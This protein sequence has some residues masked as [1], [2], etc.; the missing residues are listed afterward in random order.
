MKQFLC[1]LLSCLA[2]STAFAQQKTQSRYLPDLLKPEEG[3]YRCH[4]IPHSTKAD[5]DAMLIGGLRWTGGIVIGYQVGPYHPG[6][7]TFRLDG[8]YERLLFVMGPTRGSEGEY[9]VNGNSTLKALVG[10]YADGR[11]VLD[12][13][14]SVADVPRRYS[15]DVK[16]VQEIR[17]ALEEGETSIGFA[18]MTLWK[19]GENPQESGHLLPDKLQ[20][21]T[22]VKDLQ[23]F[24]MNNRVNAEDAFKMGGTEY[25]D[26]LDMDASVV[27][28]GTGPGWAR[29]FLQGGYA[30]LSFVAGPV[31]RAGKA[32]GTGWLT[33]KADGKILYER[34]I[35]SSDLPEPVVLDIGHCQ[36]LVFE[37]ENEDR[38]IHIGVGSIKVYPDGVEPEVPVSKAKSLPDAIKLIS[39]I[40]PYASGSS[41]ENPLFDGS[42]VHRVFRMG[43]EQ[44]NEGIVL[45]STANMLYGNSG[46]FVAFDLDGA[47]DEVHFTTGWTGNSGVMKD[48]TLRV[49]TDDRLIGTIALQATATN[50]RYTLPLNRCRK[51]KFELQGMDSFL[52]PDFGLGDI[53]V[54]RN[55]A[56]DNLFSHPAPPPAPLVNLLDISKPY[57]HYIYPLRDEME[58]ALH[59]GST[60]R[61]WFDLD[62]QRIHNG[63]LLQTSVHLTLDMDGLAGALIAL[64]FIGFTPLALAAAGVAHE[65]SVAAF[66]TYGDYDVL[67]FKVACLDGSN[68]GT[69][70]PVRETLHIGTDGDLAAT[71][72][73]METMAP[74]TFEIPLNRCKQLMFWLVCTD[75]SS[76]KYLI[77][78]AQLLRK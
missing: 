61:R 70:R 31:D 23:P 63:F 71:V 68:P 58:N 2:L 28:S 39:S 59:D 26:G 56:P 49:Y 45:Y 14:I 32:E 30:K 54:T 3:A 8:K 36:A 69:R 13:V 4:L 25:P 37:S 22:L 7:G 11:K 15:L 1:L 78:D 44:F 46:A 53:T 73:L 55:G 41:I 72:D 51:L 43:G 42:S 74:A 65:S 57:V 35:H 20:T 24:H 62:G 9:A 77:Y 64:N 5:A 48:D 40:P 29:F 75:S 33:V 34:E 12:E 6:E 17:F 19:T 38:N 47:Y 76:G 66:N 21:L 50:R 16:G 67:R 18:E 60:Q 10:V 27:M 52:R